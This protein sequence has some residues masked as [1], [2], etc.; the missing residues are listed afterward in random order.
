M[1]KVMLFPNEQRGNHLPVT[2]WQD[3]S[4]ERFGVT[5]QSFV[6]WNKPGRL[7]R[8]VDDVTFMRETVALHGGRVAWREELI[9]RCY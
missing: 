7:G 4:I 6:A 8:W 9:A 5:G 2:L 3:R 1:F